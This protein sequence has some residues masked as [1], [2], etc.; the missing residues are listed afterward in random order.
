MDLANYAKHRKKA[1]N[2]ANLQKKNPTKENHC[3]STQNNQQRNKR[4]IG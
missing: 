3:L 1:E 2:S 4:T